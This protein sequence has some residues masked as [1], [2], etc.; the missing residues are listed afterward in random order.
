M[1]DG[2]VRPDSQKSRQELL[3]E[4][5]YL[6]DLAGEREQKIRWLQRSTEAGARAIAELDRV[7]RSRSWR[8]T[9]PLRWLA[10]MSGRLSAEPR[11]SMS[12][13]SR[14]ELLDEIR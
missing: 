10:G 5:Y 9:A 12:E 1:S 14:Q 7:L 11:R 13:K 4:I 2:K 3:D 6:R 8:L